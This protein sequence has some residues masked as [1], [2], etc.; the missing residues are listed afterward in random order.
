MALRPVAQ[1][2]HTGCFIA[3]VATLLGASYKEAFALL[4]PGKDPLVELTHGFRDISMLN[5]A[6]QAL[7]R[8]GI[9]GRP[10]KYKRFASFRRGNKHAILI[11]RWEYDPTNCHTIVYDGDEHKFY[12]PSHGGEVTSKYALKSYERQLDCAIIIK[13]IPKMEFQRDLPRSDSPDTGASGEGGLGQDSS[14]SDEQ[15]PLFT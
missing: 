13:D 11:I 9:T 10:S 5:A 3:G 7:S 6:F 1:E 2:N 8:V 15:A 4:H 12:D 14:D